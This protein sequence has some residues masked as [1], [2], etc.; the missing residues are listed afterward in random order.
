MHR[1]KVFIVTDGGY[2]ISATCYPPFIDQSS[3]SCS[4]EPVNTIKGAVILA[5]GMG[6]TQRYYEAL[7]QWLS[8]KGYL[9][10]TF[11][12]LSTGA[13]S[14]EI[15]QS[16][17]TSICNWAQFDCAAI[18]DYAR[19]Q[20]GSLALYWLGH[21]LGGQIAGLIPNK[22]HL[23]KVITIACGSGYWLYNVPSLKVKV[24]WLWYVLVPLAH[25]VFG[26]FPGKRLH[27]VGNLP[28][29]VMSQWRRWCLN[30]DYLFGVEDESVRKSY[31]DWET[32][33]ISISFT[34]D[35]MMSR[36][37]IDS[38]HRFYSNASREMIRLSPEELGVKR[39]GH[40][41]FFNNKFEKSLWQ[42]YLLP[43][44]R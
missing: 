1:K 11:D 36:K 8:S 40:S 18:I 39:I 5:P 31:A 29:G 33:I 20:A 21:S 9:A 6:I 7:A 13:S 43:L 14:P 24:W 23:S 19:K 2:S 42:N 25:R 16:T 12:Y 44:L 10:V 22:H 30:S 4:T 38:L 15:I 17:N 37:S 28:K 32:A 26:Y 27:K 34:D 41:G 35:E 3:S